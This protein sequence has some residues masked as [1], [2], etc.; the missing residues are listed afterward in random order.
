[1]PKHTPVESVLII[2]D[3]PLQIAILKDHFHDCKAERILSA[4]DGAKAKSLLAALNCQPE[5]IICDLQMPEADGIELFAHLKTTSNTSKVLIISGAP[6]TQL[7]AATHLARLYGLNIIGSFRKPL[8]LDELD[9]A[10]NSI[11]AGNA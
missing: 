11:S 3:D 6:K 4:P 9:A 7:T 2:D 1:M 8:N 10:L 5:L